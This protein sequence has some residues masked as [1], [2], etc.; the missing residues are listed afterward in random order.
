MEGGDDG[1]MQ[2]S[3]CARHQVRLLVPHLVA[4]ES[5]PSL[6]ES[7]PVCGRS[8]MALVIDGLYLYSNPLS[9]ALLRIRSKHLYAK[10]DS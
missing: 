9:S 8:G 4:N 10:P 3:A 7:Q 5:R 1:G 2:L 6:L